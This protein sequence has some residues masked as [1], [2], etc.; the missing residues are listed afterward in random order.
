MKSIVKYLFSMQFMGLLLAVFATSMAVATF[1]ENDYGTDAA[2]S[3]VYNATWFELL[4]VLGMINLTG[5]IVQR[6]LYKKEKFTIFL[7][8]I[9]FVVIILG[10]GITRYIGYEGIMHIREGDTSNTIL[11][12]NTYLHFKISNSDSI[13]ET[14]KVLMSELA[15]KKISKSFELDGKEVEIAMVDFVPNAVESIGEDPNGVPMIEL[16]VAGDGGRKSV[17]IKEGETVR[18]GRNI[19]SLNDTTNPAAVQIIM[20]DYDLFIRSPF[21]FTSMSMMDQQQQVL[22]ADTLHS[23]QVRKLYSMNNQ[24]IVLND[25][26]P[27]ASVMPKTIQDA[28]DNSFPDAVVYNVTVNNESRNISAWGDKGIA[29]EF[30]TIDINGLNVSVGYGAKRIELPFS[31]K[32]KDFILERYPGSNSPS[33]YESEVIL[34]D[35]EK[36]INEERRIF[37]NN[38]LKHRGYRFYQ[39]SYDSDE[40]GTVLSVNRDALGT[41]VTYLGY[42]LLGLGMFLSIFIRNSRFQKM[43]RKLNELRKERKAIKATGLLAAFMILSSFTLQSQYIPED[44]SVSKEHAEAFGKLLVQGVDGRIEPLNTLGS[45]V[46]RKISRKNTLQGLTSDQ[47]FL[48]M[49]SYPELWQTVPMIKVSH[50]EIK[51]ILG[52]TGKLAPFNVFINQSTGYVLRQYVEQAYQKKP[53]YRNKFDTEIIKVDE[54][55]NISYMTYTS[56]LL[57]IFP[58]PEDTMQKW[59]TP[60]NAGQKFNGQDSVFVKNIVSLYFQSLGK[61]MKSGDYTESEEYLAAMKKFQEKFGEELIPPK[62]KTRL[63]VFYNN[64]GIFERLAS[65]YGIVGFIL[66]ILHFIA[67]FVPKLKLGVTIK[68]ASVFV[69]LAFIAHTGG[70]ALRWY[71]SG[72]AP[73]SNGYESMIYIGWATVLAGLIF[74]RKSEVSLSI[75]AILAFLILHVA[76]LSW[77]DP[78]V[79]NLVPVLK[80]YWLI[81]HVAIITASYGFLALAA[82]MAFLN[83]ILMFFKNENNWKRIELVLDELTGIIEMA[84]I[85]GLYMLTIGTFLGGVWANESWGRYWGWDPKETWA[86]ISVIVYAFIS[87]MRLIPG[88]RGIYPFNLFA[89]VGFSSII[90]T[91]F[92]VNYYLSGLHSYAQGDPV[93]VPTFV[94]YTLAIIVVVAVLAYVNHFKMEKYKAGLNSKNQH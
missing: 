59:Y 45:E 62:N 26:F 89:L 6:K 33:W 46:L 52:I 31:L 18:V 77:M 78:E 84:V 16:V 81:I 43:S 85:A 30:A 67:I 11:S 13:Y 72:H 61:A 21:F 57:R 3:V 27:Q 44:Q 49:M 17:V 80:S 93:P 65:V 15:E 53:A 39:S 70:L 1:I 42:F 28:A 5:S 66:L 9:S 29:P 32:L 47:V 24:Q 74:S 71:I 60:L 83:L 7:F 8:H 88:L 55:V 2:K 82:L 23:F 4:L 64:A 10:A 14:H 63:E 86:L 92:G 68:V 25:Y 40:K 50:D 36:G 38:V 12:D 19:F 76:H 91:Y 51:N 34:T 48:G 58:H 54:R 90:M 22:G 87:H 79:T 69:V 20:D 41:F 35:R 56:G 75:T 73:W 37:M 94:Y